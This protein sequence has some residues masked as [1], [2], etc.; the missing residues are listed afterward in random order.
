MIFNYLDEE[1]KIFCLKKEDIKVNYKILLSSLINM[2]TNNIKKKKYTFGENGEKLSLELI[3]NISDNK[4]IFKVNDSLKLYIDGKKKISFI[5]EDDSCLEEIKVY[6]KEQILKYRTYLMKKNEKKNIEFFDKNFK[7]ISN[8]DQNDFFYKVRY[9]KINKAENTLNEKQDGIFFKNLF[10]CYIEDKYSNEGEKLSFNLPEYSGQKNEKFSYIS[11]ESR[12]EILDSLD[13]FISSKENYLA[14][15]GTSGTGKT[16]TLLEFL[17]RI[18]KNSP[19]C[20]FNIKTLS[21]VSNIKKLASEFVKLFNSKDLYDDYIELVHQIEKNN[22]LLLWDKIIEILD[23][24]FKI[25]IISE[26]I[27][28]VIDQYKIGYDPDLKLIKMLELEKYKSRIKFIICSS[29][30]EIDMKS[31][32]TYSYIF[33]KLQLKSIL[34]YKFIDELFSVEKIIKNNEIKDMMKEFN[35]IPKYYFLFI[36]KYH[37][38]EKNVEHKEIL[39]TKIDNFLSYQFQDLKEKLIS[40]FMEND[41]DIIQEYNNICHILQGQIVNELNVPYV[42]QKIPL[43]YCIYKKEEDNL[44]ITPAFDFIYGPLRKVYKESAIADLINVGKI[45]EKKNRGELGNIFDS[46]VNYHFDINKKI[47]GLE[48]SHVVIVNEIVNFSYIKKIIHEEKDYFS[49]QINLE[50]L[51]DHKVIYLEQFNSNGQCVDGGFLIPIPNSDSYALL[52]YQS[53]I[54]KRKHFSKDFIF[55]YIYK[56]TKHNINEMLGININ[57]IYFMY[58]IAQEDQNTAKFCKDTNIYYIYYDYVNSKFL[59][60]TSQEINAFNDKIYNKMEIWETNKKLIELFNN[61][62]K[63]NDLSSFKKIFLGK[64]R[65]QK[66]EEEEEEEEGENDNK[67]KVKDF[68]KNIIKTKNGYKNKI[69][70]LIQG[71]SKDYETKIAQIKPSPENKIK[72]KEIPEKWEN[73]FN[74]YDSYKKIVTNL[75]ANNAIF[76]LPIFYTY[77]KKYLIIKNEDKKDDKYSFYNYKTGV[78]LTGSELKDA[79]DS[80]NIFSNN[81]EDILLFNAY[82][83]KKKK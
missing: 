47:F 71:N 19:H 66:K 48:I 44:I 62:E 15:T 82:C 52:L 81:S 45:M 21:K 17:H 38:D 54:K 74:E 35:Y 83:L 20:Y 9:L 11:T 23:F 24:I 51:Y 4:F 67:L 5:G 33:K 79:L 72:S 12:N 56:T 14:I 58:I 65:E 26:N 18:S 49:D 63:S 57:K 77:E 40:F 25:N 59:F 22:N 37:K 41:I 32:L 29:I 42:I 78:K 53:S 68:I 10:D 69:A 50:K 55:N 70:K 3:R 36:N 43:K 27:I 13:D 39:M 76:S 60:G 16:I 61:Q 7:L 64:K 1:L 73:I 30:H 31:N 8:K 2:K 6:N 28:I 75:Q 80:V 34:L 46:L